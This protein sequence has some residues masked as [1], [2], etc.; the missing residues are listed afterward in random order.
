MG[1]AVFFTLGAGPA[2]FSDDM[3]RIL[4]K[5]H[6]GAAAQVVLQRY[7]LFHI[8][9]A[10][11]ALIHLM[12]EW[13]YSGR[14][15]SLFSTTLVSLMLLFSVAGSLWMLPRLST[16]HREIYS[17]HSQPAQVEA[18]RR[19]FGMWHGVSQSVNLLLL[20]G[21]LMHLWTTSKDPKARRFFI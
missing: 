4:P 8:A 16:L 6:A 11:I 1:A 21:I 7:L 3:A 15:L 10:L 14:P 2:F 18:A 12:V 13:L 19:S 9:C 20:A 5:S 17:P